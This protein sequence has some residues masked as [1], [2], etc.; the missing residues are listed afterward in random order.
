MENSTPEETKKVAETYI[1]STG[2]TPSESGDNKFVLT[3]G[4]NGTIFL[5]WKGNRIVIISGLAKDQSAMADK[6]SS[7]ILK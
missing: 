1:A 2:I 4:Y 5:S 6:Y 7:A 3:D